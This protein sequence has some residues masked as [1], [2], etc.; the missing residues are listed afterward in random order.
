MFDKSNLNGKILVLKMAEC[1]FCKIICISVSV[2]WCETMKHER[3]RTEWI[4]FQLRRITNVIRAF[5]V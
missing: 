3:N 4:Q 2:N 1:Q 5:S